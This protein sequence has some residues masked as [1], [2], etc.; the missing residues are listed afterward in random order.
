[1][2]DNA[3]GE[4]VPGRPGPHTLLKIFLGLNL[5]ALVGLFIWE[6]SGPA[7]RSEEELRQVARQKTLALREAV[8]KNPAPTDFFGTYSGE[9]TFVVDATAADKWTHLSL[10]TASTFQKER[11]DKD[12]AAWDLAFR[13]AKVVTNGGATGRKGGVAVMA[14][15]TAD[16]GSVAQ[17]PAEG[18]L[19]DRPTDNPAETM[20]PV[21]D[22]WYTYDFWSHRLKPRPLI[23]IIKGID[24]HYSKFQIM[25]YYC[26][27]ASA[28]YTLRYAYQGQDTLAFA[29]QAGGK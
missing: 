3:T 7:S 20:N 24:G 14:L 26:G 25:S 8:E 10:G 2:S 9:I 23:Y 17:A 15:N 1:M 12:S 22:R 5:A 28:C 13:R 6:L 19:A 11:I 18:Y 29:N 16:F 27:S 4:Q 21:L